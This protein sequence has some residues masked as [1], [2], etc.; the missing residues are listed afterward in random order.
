MIIV[1]EPISIR[2]YGFSEGKPVELCVEGYRLMD[3][4]EIMYINCKWVDVNS[5]EYTPIK[6]KGELIG[7]NKKNTLDKI[8]KELLKQSPEGK[9]YVEY[10][11]R[12]GGDKLGLNVPWGY[13]PR[14]QRYLDEGHTLEEIY[15]ECIYKGISW[16]EMFNCYI[17][18]DPTVCDSYVVEL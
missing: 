14:V 18:N 10:N 12:I 4:T 3:D 6:I 8:D 7:F 13:P 9:A 1:K 2:N 11:E 16:E 15:R 5:N 17:D